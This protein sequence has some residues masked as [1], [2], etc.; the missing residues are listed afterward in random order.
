MV[1]V[2]APIEKTAVY[3]PVVKQARL[4]VPRGLGRRQYR[5]VRVNDLSSLYPEGQFRQV[6][7]RNAQRFVDDLGKQGY[8]LLSAE[9]DL[10]VTGPYEHRQFT[11][12]GLKPVQRH[13]LKGPPGHRRPVT[14]AG[15]PVVGQTLGSESDS[16]WEDYVLEAKFLNSRVFRVERTVKAAAS[17]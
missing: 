3:T 9:A 12:S 5:R 8:A 13:V 15:I 4:T 16:D 1:A 11:S 14:V 7:L 17:E 6:I 2:Q 10:T